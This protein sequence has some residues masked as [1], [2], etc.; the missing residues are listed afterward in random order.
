M[1]RGSILRDLPLSACGVV[2]AESP[3]MVGVLRPFL[4]R[5]VCIPLMAAMAVVALHCTAV[6]AETIVEAWRSPFGAASAVS[7]NSTDGS[8]WAATGASVMHLAADG[9]V[10]AQA[11][12]F[13]HPISVSV[14]ATDGSCW[15]M[16]NGSGDLVH[17]AEGGNEL[18]RGGGFSSGP[19]DEPSVSVNSVDGSCWVADG[20]RGDVVHLAEDG[21][22]LWR[23]DG[24]VYPTSVSVNQ[25]D[26]TCWVA[27]REGIGSGQ[28]VH[29]A[30]D[31]S[32]LWRGGGF[33][34]PSCVCANLAD[35]SCWV[36]DMSNGTV[37]LT[38]DG[39]E[40]WRENGSECPRS[41]SVIPTDGSC[42]IGANYTAI[43][44]AEDGSEIARVSGSD[45]FVVVAAD[46]VDR[47]CWMGRQGASGVPSAVVHVDE[48]GNE[49]WRG[50]T[51]SWP[52]HLSASAADGSCWVGDS[53]LVHLA[54]DG[55]ELARYEGVGWPSVI[56]ANNAD[57]SCWVGSGSQVAH[58]A[59]DG[60]E[61]WRGDGFSYPR[62]LGID[63]DDG[64]CWVAD[65]GNDRVVHLAH[66]G[67]VI[68][69]GTGYDSPNA[70]SVDAG[71]GSCWVA[72]GEGGVTHLDADGTEIWQDWAFSSPVDLTVDSSD[73]SCWIANF[74]LSEVIRLA[75]DGT[76]LWRGGMFD[77]PVS[78][79]ADPTDHSCWVAD[80]GDNEVIHLAGD[81]TELWRGGGFWLPQAV[82]VDATDGSCWVSDSESRQ[83]VHLV[84]GYLLSLQGIGGRVSTNG[85]VRSLPWSGGQ[86]S[87]ASVTLQAIPDPGCVFLHWSGDLTGSENGCSIFMDADKY[88]TAVFSR[89]PTDVTVSFGALTLTFGQVSIEGSTTV[90]VTDELPAPPPG[91]LTF[92][93]DFTYHLATTATFAGTVTVAVDY[94]ETAYP[95][96]LG[97]RLS[98]LLWDGAQWVD[99]TTAI[100]T[101]GYLIN[102]EFLPGTESDWYVALALDRPG[103]PDAKVLFTACSHGEPYGPGLFVADG[104]F[105]NVVRLTH[106]LRGEAFLPECWC[107]GCD[108][109][110]LSPDGTKLVMSRNGKLAML[111]LQALIAHPAQEPQWLLDELGY[112]IGGFLPSW[113]SDGQR[114]AFIGGPGDAQG[115]YVVNADGTDRNLLVESPTPRMEGSAWSPDGSR[116]ALWAGTDDHEGCHMW[117]VEG[118]DDPG[119][120]SVRSLAYNPGLCDDWLVWSPDGGEIAFQR[121][122]VAL[123]S[124]GPGA[125]LWVVDVTTDVQRQLTF[126]QDV[127]E[128]PVTWSPIDG[129]IYFIEY[130]W[131]WDGDPGY[132]APHG[133]VAISRIQPDGA[134]YEVLVS[135]PE[136]F[137]WT[138][139]WLPTGAWIDGMNAL[140]GESVAPKIGIV[141]AEIL[142]G[143]QAEVAY[144]GCCNTLTMYG[145][146]LGESILDWAMPAP[147]IGANTVSFLA[148]AQDPGLDSVS[149]TAHLFDLGVTN[150]PAASPGDIQL[151]TFDGLELS[152]DWGDPLDRIALAGGVR[153]I[154]FAQLEISEVI[155][156]VCADDECPV[157]FPLSVM[158]RDRSGAVMVDCNMSI[159]LLGFAGW[160]PWPLHLLPV[161]SPTTIALV[162]G[163]WSG[164]VTVADPLPELN[165]VARWED[166]GAYSNQLPTVAKGDVNWDDLV[167]V[168]DVIKTANMAIGRGEWEPWQWW[169]ADLNCDDEVDIFDVIV[170]AN[171]ALAQ[172]GTMG[173][174]RAGSAVAPAEQVAVSTDV[175]WT[176][177]QAILSVHLAD[178]GG[179]AGIQVEI[180]FDAKKLAYRGVSGG[181]LLAGATSWSVAGNDLGG[182][183]KALAYSPNLE[184][185][186][187]GDGAILRFTFDKLG[188]KSGKVKLASVKLAAADGAE[189]PCEVR[190]GKGRHKSKQR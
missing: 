159:D 158:A 113:S 157:P 150:D 135:N 8:C 107:P 101:A 134:A 28:V 175:E 114:L 71:D 24:F 27:D 91:D 130:H 122:P 104:D 146:D 155:G 19:F 88:I 32:E 103:V 45:C 77:R 115:L 57:N 48:D 63:P 40:L 15:V 62:A 54:Q 12:G 152:D 10:L 126:T 9:T 178:C 17:L 120:P 93:K 90:V 116:I 73:H 14:N 52:V 172:M 165:L 174:G 41:V 162:N 124:G 110:S 171:E 61:L 44:V 164:E 36:A 78:V 106:P 102:G 139:W 153:T 179:L 118:I 128:T 138:A 49:L 141:D 186:R 26:G 79:S 97:E 177:T 147:S 64:S 46:P 169:A 58:V 117:L 133:V 129:Y 112:E 70:L 2:P 109:G 98:L 170:C 75:G 160:D 176:D 108:W 190:K 38:E 83:V 11:N 131:A 25:S 173:V 87:N 4:V 148:Y 47:S 50:F 56:A 154:P 145:V 69:Q 111:G 34:E 142:A 92:V 84:S 37:H 20:G 167:S 127:R 6:Q 13:K 143:V 137:M 149:G 42:W 132:E 121:G 181:E 21:S 94:G 51:F 33:E 180:D 18:W 119:G 105:S 72:H 65:W 156:P 22:Q 31:G 3:K 99:I 68:W 95:P 86:L 59:P 144:T 5:T 161:V 53:A 1:T 185:L 43:H 96:V 81:G 82:S 184:L 188:K 136:I 100:D 189:V 151:L 183:V 166:I 76:E 7:V 125:D 23:G 182:I 85:D 16:D 163:A 140:P 55:A 123:R 187:G 60:A 67:T 39:T 89:E 29:L 66:D 74:G 35:G 30:A 168:F 80:N